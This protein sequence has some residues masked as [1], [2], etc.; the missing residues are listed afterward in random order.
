MD[1]IADSWLVL[2]GGQLMSLS[3]TYMIWTKNTAYRN[4]L[5]WLE[6]EKIVIL[7]G[8][9]L[10]DGSWLIQPHIT[11][12]VVEIG[13][14]PVHCCYYC[15]NATVYYMVR[16]R[17]YIIRRASFTY[18]ISLGLCLKLGGLWEELEAAIGHTDLQILQLLLLLLY[19]DLLLRWNA[20]QSLKIF[21]VKTIVVEPVRSW[22]APEEKKFAT[23]I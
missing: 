9:Q 2:A 22:P 1:T 4:E 19:T 8:L 11:H 5:V 20:A 13:K 18:L 17:F 7:L 12:T 6:L 3:I 16:Y 14:L 21:R 10:V 23:Q 15:Y